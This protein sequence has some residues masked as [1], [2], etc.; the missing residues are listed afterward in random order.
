VW[1]NTEGTTRDQR[2]SPLLFA[3]TKRVS[4]PVT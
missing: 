1:F 2:T 4:F 3:T